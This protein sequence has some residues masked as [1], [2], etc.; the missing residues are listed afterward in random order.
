MARSSPRGKLRGMAVEVLRVLSVDSH[1]IRRMRLRLCEDGAADALGYV[2]NDGVHIMEALGS[3]HEHTLVKEL[4]QALCAWNNILDQY[5]NASNIS[6]LSHQPPSSLVKGCIQ[7]TKTGG[8]GGLLFLSTLPVTSPD[9]IVLDSIN[10][11]QLA[12]EACR[13]LALLSPLLISRLASAKGQAV[14][15][16]VVLKAL[17]QVL[18]S[19]VDKHDSALPELVAEMKMD[20]LLGIGAL[21]TYEPH[22]LV[23]VDKLFP[24][25]FQAKTSRGGEEDDKFYASFDTN[26]ICLS[27]GFSEDVFAKQIAGSDPK[28]MGDWFCLQ[29]S[30]MIQAMARAEVRS[31][32]S[33]VWET[34][35]NDLLAARVLVPS[36]RGRSSSKEPAGLAANISKAS[37]TSPQ[38]RIESNGNVL[39]EV[40]PALSVNTENLDAHKTVLQQYHDVYE[41]EGA[42]V[43]DAVISEITRDWKVDDPESHSLLSGH[44]YP[45]NSLSTEKEWM[46]SHRRFMQETRNTSAG[47]PDSL[48]TEHV[49]N[50]LDGCIPSRLIQLDFLPIFDLRPESSFDFRSLV[51]PQRRYFSFRREGQLVSQLC[52]ANAAFGESDANVHWTLGFTNSSFAGEFSETLV[53]SLYRCPMIRGISFSKNDNW[54]SV[55]PKDDQGREKSA[56]LALVGMLPPSVSSIIYDNTLSGTHDLLEVTAILETMGR[57][58]ERSREDGD[59]KDAAQFGQKKG[60][61]QSFA[62]RNSPHLGSEAWNKFFD[63]LGR[64]PAR[65]SALKSH[66]LASLR[67][68]DLSGNELGDLSCSI[69]LEHALDSNSGCCLEQ[70]D[71]SRNSIRQGEHVARVLRNYVNLRQANQSIGINVSTKGSLKAPLAYLNLGSNGLTEGGLALEVVDLLKH[72]ALSLNS[73]DLSENGLGSKGFQF[74]AVLLG[75]LVENTCLCHLNLSGNVFSSQCIDHLLDGLNSSE[76]GSSLAFLR[77]Q[78]NRPPLTTSQRNSLN[79]FEDISRKTVLERYLNGEPEGAM[80]IL[81]QKQPSK[82]KRPSLQRSSDVSSVRNPRKGE[83]MITVLFS[84]PLVFHD[85]QRKNLHPFAK[86]DFDTERELLWQ[87]LEE[88]RRD[89]E[90]FFDNA[91]TN[92]LLTA[93]TKRCSCLHYSGHGHPTHLPFEDEKG[94]PDW[95][96]VCEIKKLVEQN[97]GAPFKFVFV[98]ACH[99]LLAGET[100]ASAGVPH[101]VCCQEDSE[102]KD[103]AALAFT[104]HFYFALAVGDTVKA[105]FEQ[106]C[107]AVRAAPSLRNNAEEEMKKFILLPKD[108]NHDVPVFNAKSIREWPRTAMGSSRS[109]NTCGSRSSELSV[110]NMMQEVP[111]PKPP[112]FFLG[113]EVDMYHVLNAVITRRLVSVLGAKGVGRSSLLYAL[114]RYINERRSTIMVIN[115][116]FFVK[117]A[118]NQ[119][120]NRFAALLR[121]LLSQQMEATGL[122]QEGIENMEPES[123][124]PSICKAFRKVK[125]LLVIDKAHILEG[126]DERQDLVVFLRNLFQ[127]PRTEHVKVLLTG[128]EPLGIPSLGGVSEF[129]YTVGPMNFENTVRLFG[130]LCPHLPTPVDRKKFFKE[131]LIDETQLYLLPTDEGTT[132][133]TKYLFSIL[134]DGIPSRIES[135]AQSTPFSV[136]KAC[137]IE[138]SRES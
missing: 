109:I 55:R 50:L 18:S 14:W 21:A 4:H 108:G 42:N 86:L 66:P 35:L 74:T 52:E 59:G 132:E 15:S 81:P 41:Q 44:I 6:T 8:L 32:L 92:R 138:S 1:R 17:A 117:V 95:V 43:Q 56:V 114:C 54:C 64:S 118:Q 7:F 28:L 24:S 80:T 71:L 20:A 96:D 68:L 58:S 47:S 9:Q 130:Y 126:S 136:I 84:A 27:L 101:V 93:K 137:S 133:R 104:R 102:L 67:V 72:N 103:S 77:L 116:I 75:S 69:M 128:G 26:Q 127:D 100:F 119:G 30:L 25:L 111:S 2:I 46:L 135:A 79:N 60:S 82:G 98:S 13:S 76:T 131:L 85:V 62:I 115:R 78:D 38:A 11:S 70:L 49:Q 89:I 40:F 94:G 99:S 122:N 134:G 105:S 19:T 45:L 97:E 90:L 34:P 110:R 37:I 5:D 123:L 16:V 63:L 124:I 73:L 106:G 91:T 87:C 112:E 83:N 129:S 10:E 33:Q 3:N 23:I 22:K 48:M 125:A 12:F 61:F 57:L 29:R 121:E 107:N 53:Q 51:M 31:I 113:R 88:A 120:P 39:D 36:G 65:S